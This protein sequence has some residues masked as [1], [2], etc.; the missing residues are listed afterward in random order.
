MASVARAREPAAVWFGP[1]HETPDY[2][3]LF[4]KPQLWPKARQRVDVILLG[5][6]Q[7][8]EKGGT[9][10]DLPALK[11]VDA[12]W[13]IQEWNIDIAVEAPSVKE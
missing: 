13:K 3:D 4:A 12:F 7:T 2:T 11:N 6:T 9:I 1:A 8:I 5:P 10:V